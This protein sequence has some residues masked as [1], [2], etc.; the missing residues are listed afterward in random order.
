MARVHESRATHIS[1]EP[2][3]WTAGAG[4]HRSNARLL[5]QDGVKIG[6]E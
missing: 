1:A 2:V 5:E 3:L 4:R 6:Y